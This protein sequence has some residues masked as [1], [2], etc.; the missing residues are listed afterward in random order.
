MTMNRQDRERQV[1]Q[2]YLLDRFID[3]K[4]IGEGEMQDRQIIHHQLG[5]IF[6]IPQRRSSTKFW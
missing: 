3:G 2:N 5:L 6:S 4:I 1:V